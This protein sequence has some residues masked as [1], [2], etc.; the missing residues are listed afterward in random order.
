MTKK[1]TGA[2]LCEQTLKIQADGR[3]VPDGT[4][5]RRGVSTC[6]EQRGSTVTTNTRHST[7]DAFVTTI[8]PKT[9][10]GV[11]TFIDELRSAGGVNV[12]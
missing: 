3:E 4:Q 12:A 8:Y 11:V 5:R 1:R 6:L 2:C 7:V 9:L 10:D